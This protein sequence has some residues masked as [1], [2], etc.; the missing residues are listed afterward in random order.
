M[1]ELIVLICVIA[2]FVGT[3]RDRGQP[4]LLWA[5]VAA[6][7]Y[8]LPAIAF[9]WYIFPFLVRNYLPNEP[10]FLLLVSRRMSFDVSCEDLNVQQP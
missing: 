7:S 8:Y 6:V 9:G 10:F 4:P 1:I 2:W 3:A 5:L